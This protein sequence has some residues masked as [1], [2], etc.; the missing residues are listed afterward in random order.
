MACA[1]RYPRKMR[2][3]APLLA[4]LVVMVVA[5]WTLGAMAAG[6]AAART[7]PA[8]NAAT[9]ATAAPPPPDNDA[10]KHARR[11][12]CLQGAKTK[13]LV[14]APKAAFIKDCIAAH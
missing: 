2:T 1:R 8:A 14:G 11:T 6:G 10:A 5:L 12:A 4:V 9:A 13:K 3:L 7:P